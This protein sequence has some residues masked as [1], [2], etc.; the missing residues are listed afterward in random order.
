MVNK[1]KLYKIIIQILITAGS[2]FGRDAM[3]VRTEFSPMVEFNPMFTA[4]RSPLRMAPY[5]ITTSFPMFTSPIIE[6]FGAIHESEERDGCRSYILIID[7]CFECLSWY[8]FGR[9]ANLVDEGADLTI[10]I[11]QKKD[12]RT[13]SKLSLT[14]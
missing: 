9:G 5:Q 13:I 2:P 8:F 6:A 12:F 3:V 11:I 14:T 1:K 4:L 7:L 10:L